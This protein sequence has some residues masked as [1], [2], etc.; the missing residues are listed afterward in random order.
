MQPARAATAT[1]FSA[2]G[3][4]ATLAPAGQGSA[5]RG[6]LA[7]LNGTLDNFLASQKDPFRT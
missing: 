7:R 2:S 5:T 4:F 6:A 1:T 3:R